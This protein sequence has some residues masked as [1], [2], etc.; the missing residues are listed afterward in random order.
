MYVRRKYLYNTNNIYVGMVN[1]L[2]L[3]LLPLIN[4]TLGPHGNHKSLWM[5]KNVLIL[6]TTMT[7]IVFWF[8]FTSFL[9][10]F[11]LFLWMKKKII[12]K[13]HTK[14]EENR[15]EYAKK[16]VNIKSKQMGV[17]SETNINFPSLWKRKYVQK[18]GL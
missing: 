5:G 2:F 16:N 7:G 18:T 11:Y 14:N 12:I 6:S 10:F 1:Q 4:T 8:L 9:N 17:V 15:S 13:K 3:W